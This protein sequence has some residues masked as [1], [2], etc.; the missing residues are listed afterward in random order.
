MTW[1]KSLILGL[2]AAALGASMEAPAYANARITA[3]TDVNFGTI[4]ASGDQSIS[5]NVCAYASQGFFGQLNYSVRATGSGSGGAFQLSSGANTL[6]YEVQWADS[7]SQTGGVLLQSG[8]LS[9]GFGNGAFFQTCQFQSQ[10]TA[11]LTV[12]IRA[13]QLAV[14]TAGSYSGSLQI[15]IV[16]E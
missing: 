11:T 3:L 6:P 14:A 10:G 2:A 16:P 8:S 4:V 15:T 13:A 5:Q 9:S 1:G 12:T 7:P